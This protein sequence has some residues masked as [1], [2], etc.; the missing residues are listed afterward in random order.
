MLSTWWGL[1]SRSCLATYPY[2]GII[3]RL[4]ISGPS[5]CCLYRARALLPPPVCS[6][7]A[8]TRVENIRTEQKSA[9]LSYPGFGLCR[10]NLVEVMKHKK[11]LRCLHMAENAGSIGHHP[12]G[13]RL[14]F[15]EERVNVAS[16]L[17]NQRAL[18]QQRGSA[19]A[20]LMGVVDGIY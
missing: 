19:T 11:P 2:L 10:R 6:D 1:C 8:A 12:L 20:K 16:V 7:R 5:H 14:H 9:P 18:V 17:R 3:V 15:Q 4:S 13:K